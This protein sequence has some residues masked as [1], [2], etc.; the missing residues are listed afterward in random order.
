MGIEG[1][2]TEKR[3][4]GGGNNYCLEQTLWFRGAGDNGPL[5]PS[6]PTLLAQSSGRT[7]ATP[8]PPPPI[9]STHVQG[10]AALLRLGG[11]RMEGQSPFSYF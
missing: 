5:R 1:S 6:P 11:I 4:V 2:R 10:A 8:P 7:T 3:R 9:L